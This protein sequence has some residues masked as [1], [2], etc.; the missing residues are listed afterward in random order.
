MKFLG[1]LPVLF[2]LTAISAASAPAVSRDGAMEKLALVSADDARTWSPAECTAAPSTVRAK[3]GASSW[4]WHVDVDYFA[5]EAKYPI[6]WPRI[7]HAIPEGGLR[8]WSAW[9]FLHLWVYVETSRDALPREPA[10]LGLL[11]PDRA[12]GYNRALPELQ[13]DQWVEINL[14]IG[15]IPRHGDVR[16]IQFHLTEANYRHGDRV[17]F[18]LNDLALARY[19]EPTLCELAPEN[20]VLFSDAARLAVRFKLLGV[21][22]G[23]RA[24]VAC[25]LS[26]AGKIAA[27]ASADATRGTQR[28]LLELGH[29]RLAPGNYELR[30]TM[31]GRAQPA[32]TSVRVVESP[33]STP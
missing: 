21:K 5:G 4:R 18:Y 15:E 6:G 3:V 17:D 27:R 22:A 11:T 26:R 29:Q 30:A 8:D 10:G 32:T 14:P 9:D 1:L 13:K 19:A 24:S 12:G 2:G 7:G 16:N 23:E 28:V 20:A 33:W 31:A 25:E